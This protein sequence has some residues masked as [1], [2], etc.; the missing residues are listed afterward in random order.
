M[1]YEK[2]GDHIKQREDRQTHTYRRRRNEEVLFFSYLRICH[3]R[4]QEI[5]IKRIEEDFKKEPYTS[6]EIENHH[7]IDKQ[8]TQLNILI[9]VFLETLFVQ[10]KTR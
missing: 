1:K 5:I 9:L 8:R 2:H 10:S 4:K 6:D 7:I 3:R